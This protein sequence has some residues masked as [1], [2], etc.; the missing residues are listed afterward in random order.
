MIDAAFR[1]LVFLIAAAGLL[2]VNLFVLRAIGTIWLDKGATIVPF[3][4]V[5]GDQSLGPAMASLLQARLAELQ[6]QLQQVQLGLTQSQ[7]ASCPAEPAKTVTEEHGEAGKLPPPTPVIRLISVPVATALFQPIDLSLNVGGVD[8]GSLL[9]WMQRTMT[10]SRVMQFTVSFADKEAVIAGDLAPLTGKKVGLW[11]ETKQATPPQIADLLAHKLIAASSNDANLA[12]LNAQDFQ[13]FTRTL[14]AVAEL[15]QRAARGASVRKEFSDQVP[16]LVDLTRAAPRW[17]D[18]IY[19]AANVAENAGD[20]SQ[21]LVLYE[22]LRTELSRTS[23]GAQTRASVTAEEVKSKLEGLRSAPPT[24]FFDDLAPRL[25]SPTGLFE[26]GSNDPAK[27]YGSVS[28]RGIGGT[29]IQFGLASWSLR[30]G[31][32]TPLLLKMRDTN[33]QRFYEL[34]GSGAEGIDSLLSC[35][36]KAA[37]AFIAQA[38]QGGHLDPDWQLRFARLG[39]E[40]EFQRVQVV[41]LEPFFRRAIRLADQWGLRSE[42]GLSQMF[43]LVFFRGSMPKRASEA[44]TAAIEKFREDE[45]REPNERDRMKLIAEALAESLPGTL[46][47]Q[48]PRMRELYFADPTKSNRGGIPSLE[49]LG[50]GQKAFRAT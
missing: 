40:P 41:T 6:R 24:G 13:K 9:G 20:N 26:F 35:D 49:E 29:D 8:V 12:A 34:I 45:H 30:R 33:P 7:A 3:K 43:D 10:S 21:A 46:P 39:A 15:N 32:L 25:L 22:R 18:L 17:I 1:F 2:A 44:V 47:S 19:F 28:T 31:T 23:A 38:V 16:G 42:Q 11:L 50:L 14:S 48:F 37:A 5:G 36:P 27:M 4:V